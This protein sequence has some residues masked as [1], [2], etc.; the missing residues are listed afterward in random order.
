MTHTHARTP[1]MRKK[2]NESFVRI[3]RAW[4]FVTKKA[5]HLSHFLHINNG[6]RLNQTNLSTYVTQIPT[7]VNEQFF[8]TVTIDSAHIKQFPNALI[9]KH[10]KCFLIFLFS[11]ILNWP[12]TELISHARNVWWK[13]IERENLPNGQ[14]A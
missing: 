13:K 11:H 14:L 3:K 5:I 6:D 12:H 10:T 2:E 7:V 9:F 8:M 1:K 4:D